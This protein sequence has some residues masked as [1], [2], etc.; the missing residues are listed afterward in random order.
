MTQDD[1]GQLD[2]Y[3]NT[4]HDYTTTIAGFGTYECG[5]DIDI[6]AQSRN[7]PLYCFDGKIDEIM[8]TIGYRNA[9]WVNATFHNQNKTTGFLTFGNEVLGLTTSITLCN[10][11][12]DNVTWNGTAGST[13]YCNETGADNETVH[14]KIY[15]VSGDTREYLTVFIGNLTKNVKAG[16]ISIQF[17]SDNSTWSRAGTWMSYTNDGSNITITNATWSSTYGCYGST[18][19]TKSANAWT[20]YMG[21]FT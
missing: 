13:V 7:G 2:G 8:I 5:R 11:T 12:N 19:F 9:S 1:N 18:P 4:S 6:A 21:H 16:N 14:I 3:I 17:S 20:V 15:I 10:L